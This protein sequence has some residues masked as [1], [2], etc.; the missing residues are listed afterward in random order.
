MESQ[1]DLINSSTIL[2]EDHSSIL[3]MAYSYESSAWMSSWELSK[4]RE[5]PAAVIGVKD[6]QLQVM[7]GADGWTG[8]WV[9]ATCPQQPA[10]V[11]VSFALRR[12]FKKASEDDDIAGDTIHYGLIKLAIIDGVRAYHARGITPDFASELSMKSICIFI[13][14]VLVRR[15]LAVG[16]NV[17][18]SSIR[19]ML[20]KSSLRGAGASLTA[21]AIYK[22]PSLEEQEAGTLRSTGHIGESCTLRLHDLTVPTIIGLLPKERTM[23]QNVVA[24]IEI[25]R[26][27]G[28]GD[29][30]WDIQQI[31]VKTIE[32]SSFQTL[33]ALAERISKNIIRHSLIPTM[34]KQTSTKDKWDELADD[35]ADVPWE[36]THVPR[37]C[38]IV[39][40]KLE[41]PS[42]Y[43]D[44]TP[45]VEMSM[46]IR[47]SCDSPYFDLWEGYKRLRLCPRPLIGTLTDWIAQEHPGGS[48]DGTSSNVVG[49]NRKLDGLQPD[50]ARTPQDAKEITAQPGEHPENP[51]DG[52]SPRLDLNQ[53]LDGSQTDTSQYNDNAEE[54]V[55]RPKEHPENS[56]DGEL[57]ILS[58]LNQ[59]LK[60]WQR[61]IAQLRKTAQGIRANAKK[62]DDRKSSM[63]AEISQLLDNFRNELTNVQ[64]A[65]Q[66]FV[67][68]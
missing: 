3:N 62:L 48:K 6:L 57:S 21:Q 44:T 7:A 25:D 61:D 1:A 9:E 54:T 39:K 42:I 17:N 34:I 23:K 13:A 41:K 36:E 29:L 50:L 40:I 65:M 63:L 67:V 5:E 33:E 38:P 51:Q 26:W 55:T 60:T 19:I 11:S 64:K 37:I 47:P 30:H 59:E 18:W 15:S 28:L 49:I 31:V 2:S 53:K 4:A 32:E 46:D 43:V 20:P 35:Y 22:E 52:E 10:L 16:R 12:P 14:S 58:D 45:G 56:K 27:Y 68:Q 66:E 8:D 24:N